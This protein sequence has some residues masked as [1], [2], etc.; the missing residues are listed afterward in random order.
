MDAIEP[1]ITG[2]QDKS[3]HRLINRSGA[4]RLDFC[5]M[6]FADDTRNGT[7]NGSRP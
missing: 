4:D 6:M 1:E 7:S 2:C 5:A 3:F